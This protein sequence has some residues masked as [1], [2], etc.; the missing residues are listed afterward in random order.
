MNLRSDAE[1]SVGTVWPM[2]D[3]LGPNAI[4][5][6]FDIPMYTLGAV[7][8]VERNDEI[9]LL[10]RPRARRWPGSGS[11]PAAPSSV[12]SCPRKAHRASCAKRLAGARWV[13]PEDM[14]ALLTED[15]IT[16]LA[17]DNEIIESL[18]RHIAIDLDTS[19]RRTGSVSRSDG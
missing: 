14:Q 7:V 5:A 11:C 15:F 6:G 19:I 18:L 3:R 12:A 2:E 17:D 9:L 10:Q 16:Q 13:R 1:G 4:E 8:Y